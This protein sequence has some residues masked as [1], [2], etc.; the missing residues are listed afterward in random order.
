MRCRLLIVA[1]V[2][3]SAFALWGCASAPGR[4]VPGDTPIVPSEILDFNALY[5]A[6]CAGCHG[7]NGKGGAA[8]ALADPVYLAIADDAVVRRATADGISG[9][10]MPAFAQSAGGMLTDK[11]IEAIVRGIR[12][13]GAQPDALR[14]ANPPPYSSSAAG[15]PSRGS[16][17]YTEYCSS[18]HGAGGRGGPKASSIVDGS[19][20]ALLNDQE[21]RTIA[22]VGRPD[23]GAPD[24][25]GNIP[26]KPMSSQEISDVVAWLASQRPKFPGQPYPNSAG[27]T[28][29]VR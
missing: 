5:G 10:S 13:H 2:S 26:G 14:G 11:Q 15:D 17:V 29:D 8:I 12:E 4:P 3:L 1:T 24:W 28:G 23:L 18:C 19:F 6:N 21:L 20:L 27:L 22:I 16:F 25:R 7:D 9:T